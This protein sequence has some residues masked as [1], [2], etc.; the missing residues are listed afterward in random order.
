L[1]RLV[2]QPHVLDRYHRLIGKGGDQLNLVL[3]ERLRLGLG[4]E[5]HADDLAIAQQRSAQSSPEAPDL[6]GIGP[7]EFGIG[8]HIGNMHNSPLQR[9]ATG[10]TATIDV[11][12]P[13]QE[14][15]PETL[16]NFSVVAEAG[17]KPQQIAVALEQYG[18]VRIAKVRG[19]LYQGV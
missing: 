6:L 15:V 8:Q 9:A 13:E 12:F 16:V 3:A 1:L 7:N 18:V 19:R 10:D 14:K 17:F 4:N 5:N 11:H 2:E